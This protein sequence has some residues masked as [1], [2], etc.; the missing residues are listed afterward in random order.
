MDFFHPSAVI[1]VGFPSLSTIL[2]RIHPVFS[3]VFDKVVSAKSF[4][5]RLDAIM[6][7]E[8]RYVLLRQSVSDD[9][10]LVEDR[11]EL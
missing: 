6:R 4:P 2:Y 5:L 7:R 9:Y 10:D 11:A 8:R 3:R 1:S